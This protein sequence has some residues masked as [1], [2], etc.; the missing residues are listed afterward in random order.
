MKNKKIYQLVTA[1]LAAALIMVS[2]GCGGDNSSSKTE[3]GSPSVSEISAEESS[4]EEASQEE[5]SEEVSEES[6]AS[7]ISVTDESEPS[8]NSEEE[9]SESG[10]V[11]VEDTA[12]KDYHHPEHFT[13]DEEF[14]KLFEENQIDQQYKLSAMECETVADMRSIAQSYAQVWSDHA[15]K[16]YEKLYELL[17][18]YPS[19]REKLYESNLNWKNGINEAEARFLAENENGGTN[20]LLAAD[21]SMLNFFKYRA[22]YLYLQ[23][24]E[25]TGSFSPEY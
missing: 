10:Y 11:F 21:T 3:S 14:N 19:E 13:G 2:A 12:E 5:S 16:A 17:E 23:I 4:A 25:L 24:Y 1:V 6:D 7:E 22:A 9:S 18:E 15:D 8:L 20:G